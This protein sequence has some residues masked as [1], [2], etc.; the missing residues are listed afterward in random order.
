MRLVG[1]MVV[2]ASVTA[3][4]ARPKHHPCA[5]ALVV[6]RA[7]PDLAGIKRGAADMAGALD[8]SDRIAVIAF[9][10]TATQVVALQPS[11]NTAAITA[12]INRI[13]PATDGWN[14][15]V[16]IEAAH[17]ALAGR[18]EHCKRV[19]VMTNGTAVIGVREAA[20]K[21]ALDGITLSAIGV[22]ST[23]RTTL[24]AIA[25]GGGRT[26]Q[27]SGGVELARIAKREMAPDPKKETFAVVL[28]IDR[29]VGKEIEVAKEIGRTTVEVMA[30]DDIVAVVAFDRDV[31]VVARPERAANRMRISAEIARITTSA[32]ANVFPALREA[33]DLLAG[34]NADHEHVIVI[35]DGQFAMDG[36]ADLVDEIAALD[37]TVSAVGVPGADRQPLSTIAERGNGR[38]YLA[39][40]LASIPKLLLRD[41]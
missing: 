9:D 8:P 26:Y 35:S 2:L 21:L 4:E 27:I 30:P 6:D 28:L 3:A 36:V 41:R 15:L 11:T 23:N 24:A 13:A 10:G 17:K 39:W 33:K 12:G 5:V 40:D 29:T 32:G 20:R 31:R 37:V 18:S 1:V 7:L 22:K 25:S 38:L 19:L 14:M 16:G 34:I